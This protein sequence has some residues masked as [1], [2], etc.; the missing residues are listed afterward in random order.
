MER[1]FLKEGIM[2]IYGGIVMPLLNTVENV[3]LLCSKFE[4]FFFLMGTEHAFAYAY[5]GTCRALL[6]M[7]GI[8]LKKMVV[9]ENFIAIILG[10]V[11][12]SVT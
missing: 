6:S 2:H 4:L 5:L 11:K 12:V 1:V 10:L 7:N 9:M 8:N 3:C